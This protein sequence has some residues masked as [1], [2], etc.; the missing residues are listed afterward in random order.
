MSTEITLIPVLKDNYSY[1]IRTEE[2]VTIIIDPADAE[3]IISYLESRSL[4]LDFIINTHHHWDHTD[5]NIGLKQRYQCKILGPKKDMGRIKGIDGGLIEDQIL[6]FGQTEARVIETPG[7]TSG[8]ISVYFIKEKALFCGD[9]L[10]SM[11]CGRLFEGTAEELWDSFLKILNLPDET[12]IY[13]GHEYTS[14]NGKFCMKIEPDNIDLKERMTEVKKLRAK[15]LP[16][17]PVSLLTEKKTNVFLRAGS[18]EALALL[19]QQ[20]D[21]A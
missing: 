12:L 8:H 5:G 17:I 9:T 15:K 1:L 7:H 18:A 14:A 3:E 2:G 6:N 11:G 4:N 16:T 20:K 13:C 19:R 10:F 21:A